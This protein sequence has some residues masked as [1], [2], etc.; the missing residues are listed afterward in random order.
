MT[1]EQIITL[2]I[3]LAATAGGLRKAAREDPQRLAPL[4]AC[5]NRYSRQ[6]RDLLAELAK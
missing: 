5:A 4:V 2:A 6:T 3:R 1:D